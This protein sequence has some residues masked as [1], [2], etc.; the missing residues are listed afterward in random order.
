MPETIWEQTR[1]KNREANQFLQA[2]I[3]ECASCRDMQRFC[4]T[5]QKLIDN[6]ASSPKWPEGID[7]I[8]SGQCPMNCGSPMGCVFCSF[9][10]M[11]ECHYPQSCEEARCSH[12]LRYEG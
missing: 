4:E 1:Q 10:H 2:H 6:A 11:N 9:G 5:G 3:N 8:T 12:L 7:V